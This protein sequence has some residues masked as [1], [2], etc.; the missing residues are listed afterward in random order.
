[1]LQMKEVVDMQQVREED[2]MTR[3]LKI[4]ENC[5]WCIPVNE[6]PQCLLSGE[7]KGLFESCE[8]YKKRTANHISM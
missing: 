4:C 3:S 8:L 7:Q 2:L 5:E 6:M 1:M